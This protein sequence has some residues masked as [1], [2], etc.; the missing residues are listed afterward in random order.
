MP[1]WTSIE[2]FRRDFD[3]MMDD[4][5]GPDKRKI[6]RAQGEEGQKIAARAAA[7]DLGGDRAFSGWVRGNPIRLETQLR[8]ARDFN[9]LI[10]PTRGSAGPW[11]VAEFGR[12]QGNASGFSGPGINTRTGITSRTK[13][14]AVRRVRA[15]RARRWN[16]TTRPKD[17]AT[18]ALKVMEKELPKVADKAVRLIVRKRFDAT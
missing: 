9:T 4:L 15:R 5:T 10:T 16:G 6:T 18:D 2:A 1:T 8:N 12:N 7:R 17:T 13:S 14:G 3:R 11:T